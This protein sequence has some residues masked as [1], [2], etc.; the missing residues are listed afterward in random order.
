MTTPATSPPVNLT[1]V[2][3]GLGGGI[4]SAVLFYSAARGSLGLS[5]LLFLLT[6]MP[7]LIV[8]LGWGLTAAVAAAI[9]GAL[10][11]AAAVAP[12]AAVGYTLAL[13]IPVAGITHLLYLAQ[14]APDGSLRDWYPVGRV[15]AAIAL[16]GAALPVVVISLGSGSFS[17][18][19]PEFLRFLKQM[20]E[21]APIG[22]GW[23]SFSDTQLRDMAQMWTQLMP[24]AVASYWTFFMG[25]N[26]YL[27]ARIARLS[28]L[29]V[30]P[31]PN[32]H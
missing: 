23:R 4:A 24:A 2:L 6:P 18:L 10:V 12:V 13:G 19:E 32:L 20:T 27:A 22:S 17:N 7:S 26:T 21:R 29:L 15:L 31:W 8:G 28:G 30:R 11:M 16:Y 25:L 3:F 14:Y 5:M 1:A 9:A